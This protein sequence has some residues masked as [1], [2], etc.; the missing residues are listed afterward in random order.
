MRNAEHF[1]YNPLA[2]IRVDFAAIMQRMRKQSASESVAL[3]QCMILSRVAG[4]HVLATRS[5]SDLMR[6]NLTA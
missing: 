4:V 5:L 2:D 3:V 1:A 6:Y